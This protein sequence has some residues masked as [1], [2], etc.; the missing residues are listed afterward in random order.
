MGLFTS[1]NFDS[2]QSNLGSSIV[3]ILLFPSI[4][5]TF[6]SSTFSLSFEVVSVVVE[7]K[8]FIN[9][10]SLPSNSASSCLAIPTFLNGISLKDLLGCRREDGLF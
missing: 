1:K 9:S 8:T 7:D 10:M 2:K 5:S 6:M 4:A 3:V